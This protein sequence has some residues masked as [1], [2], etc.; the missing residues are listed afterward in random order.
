VINTIQKKL[1]SVVNSKEILATTT[2][3]CK[4]M[5]T[6]ISDVNIYKETRSEGSQG[7]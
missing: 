3:V 1:T 7:R 2:E 5:N 6:E 4:T